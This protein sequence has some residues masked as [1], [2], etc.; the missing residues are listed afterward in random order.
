MGHAGHVARRPLTVDRGVPMRPLSLVPL[1]AACA[2]PSLLIAEERAPA[3]TPASA[4]TETPAPITADDPPVVVTADRRETDA[5][6]STASVSQVDADDDRERGYVLDSWRWLQGLA[7]VDAAAGYG[8]ID[9]GL[10]RLR[11]RGANSFDT[12]W[13]V[14]GIPVSDPSTPQGNLP[15]NQLPT[16]GLERV[17]VVRGAQSGLYGSRAVGGVVNLLT[18]R[19]TA[20]HE[21]L[22]RA[23]AGSFGT[24]RGVAQAT[25]PLAT[26]L[27]YA[28]AVD[29][30]HSDG[31]SARTDADAEGDARDHEADSLDRLGANG[32]LEWQAHAATSLYLAARYQ[33]IN[34]EFDAS[35][36]DDLLSYS[37]TR[38][39]GIS[40]G[41]RTR[42][43][44]RLVV[45]SDLSWLGS[46]RTYREDGFFGLSTTGYDGDQR[47]AALRGR[48]L[49]TT[50]L[51][52]TVGADGGRESL[53]TVTAGASETHRDWL[54]GGWIQLYS[55]GEHHDV[56]LSTRTD[57]HSR[58]GD[59]TTWRAAA[60]GHAL[61]RSVT[62]RGAAGTAF[63][64]PSLGEMFA[65]FGGNPQLEAQES[66]SW[67]AGI[68]LAPV[69]QVA[70]ESTW[71]VNDYDN[72]IGYF[73]PDGFAGPLPGGYANVPSYEVRGWEN[74]IELALWER[75][76]S[77]RGAYTWQEVVTVPE[78]IFDSFSPYLPRHL[79]NVA[80]IARGEP[81]WVRLGYTYRGSA[82]T[83]TSGTFLDASSVVDVAIGAALGRHWEVSARVDNLFDE[84]YE[85]NP[86]FTTSG[87]AF[88]GGVAAR[89]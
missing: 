85:V 55:A 13:L 80:V 71:F 54:G 12:Q 15:T 7:G 28:L 17:E 65:S 61:E 68:R 10:G 46:D 82:P 64:A 49:A 51:E 78:D 89:F 35:G 45:E 76:L 56:S 43:G 42:L 29:G 83:T 50:W 72:V 21:I 32:R 69:A 5:T 59:A 66:L 88:Y 86:G 26:G 40:G 33:A 9:G 84:D 44:E 77:L 70:L 14:D 48:Y 47:R 58:A 8:G 63:R 18:A 75:H 27:G 23:E 81:G 2:V 53:E 57:L 60:A 67:D 73:D 24:A 37:Q 6:R 3:P 22:G 25:G 4:T 16:A 30:L 19:P 20:G 87:L 62:V 31:F 52:A 38:T 79:A 1:L 36:P 41:S 34:Q 39:T 11:I 74:A